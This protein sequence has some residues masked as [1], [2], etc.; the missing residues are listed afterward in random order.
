MQSERKPYWISIYTLIFIF[1]YMI[2]F[3]NYWRFWNSDKGETPFQWDA[4]QYYSYLP[5]TFI[6][7]DLDFSYTTRYWLVTAPNGKV[8]PKMTCGVAM[9]MSPFFLLG[10]KVAMNQGDVLDGYS[11]PYGTCVHYGS[12][13]YTLLG[14]I[15]LVFVLRRFY[16]DGITALTIATLFFATNLFYYTFRDGEM[17]HSY[18]FFLVSLFLWLTCRWHERKKSIYFLWLGLTIGLASLVRPT[19]ILIFLVFVG[20][21]V[22]SLAGLKSK[23]K[24]I[25]FSV[26]NIPLFL[27]GFFI[28]WAPQLILW[29]VKT[30][31]FLFFSY[32]SK[33]GFFW[34]DP[35]IINL[36]FSY[37][38]GLFIYTPVMIFAFIGLFFVL[39]NKTS[40]LKLPIII[41]LAINIYVLSCWWC[42]WYGGGFGMRAL[43]QAFAFLAIP[44]AAFYH[45]IFS[46]NFK[47]NLFTGLARGI[48]IAL[49]SGFV[50]LNIIQTYQYDHPAEHRLLHYDSMSKAAYWH[51][52]GKFDITP[53][54][55]AKFEQELVHP[56]NAA[57]LNGEKR[58]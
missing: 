17:A 42:W 58:D 8:V 22:R 30:G 29:K 7:H 5:A 14:L 12:L 34:L 26:K 54:E 33:E 35:Q 10:H 28:M 19:E 52:F 38:K 24:E 15:L 37:R 1:V 55:F 45:F 53:E 6:Y 31:S 51:T 57:T 50:S 49:F 21:G 4:D 9:M 3:Q 20:Y 18:S 43:V 41:Y 2:F 44:L 46:L 56:D 23:L 16:S 47:K 11:E 27:L 40:D 39:R 48:A 25:V 36:L 32:G 13:F